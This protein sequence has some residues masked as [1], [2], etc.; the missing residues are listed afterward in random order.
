MRRTINIRSTIGR[1]SGPFALAILLPVLT[2]TQAQ[3]QATDLVCSECVQASDLAPNAV[4]NAKI[5]NGAVNA[6]KLASNAVTVAKIANNSIA[7]AKLTSAAVTFAKIGPN[8]VRTS[9]IPNAAVTA[10]KIA[11][12][13]VNVTKLADGAI[14]AAKLAPDALFQNTLV[15]NAAGPSDADNC[16]ALLDTLA[17]ITD[18]SASNSYLIQLSPG[19]YDCGTA[20]IQMKDFVSLAGAGPAATEITGSYSDTDL[21]TGQIEAASN[22]EL[23]GLALNMDFACSADNFLIGLAGNSVSDFR[24]ADLE[25]SIETSFAGCITFGAS[26]ISSSAVLTTL[27][28]RATQTASADSTGI[29]VTGTSGPA[30]ITLVNVAAEGALGLLVGADTETRARNSRINGSSVGAS[31]TMDQGLIFLAHSEIGGGTSGAGIVCSGSFDE[32]FSPLN[33]NCE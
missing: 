5:G 24:A 6:A 13:A 11:P 14:T 3:A 20:R 10:A 8:A 33:S 29:S 17:G 2:A 7:A 15:V 1:A 12:G 25:I 27:E 22:S 19:T 18:N 4:N 23:R 16:Q 28:A 31:T 26:L 9:K 21:A 30:A 32:S